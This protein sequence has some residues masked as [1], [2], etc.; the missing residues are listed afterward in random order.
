MGLE[1]YNLIGSFIK[2]PSD[3]PNSLQD[4]KLL[5]AKD[6]PASV[7]KSILDK[8]VSAK[9]LLFSAHDRWA[10]IE[11][12]Y[13]DKWVFWELDGSAEQSQ[14]KLLSSKLNSS[15]CCYHPNSLNEWL[16]IGIRDL[17]KCWKET[18]CNETSLDIDR[19]KPSAL[20]LDMKPPGMEMTVENTKEGDIHPDPVQYLSKKYYESLF[21]LRTPLAIFVKSKLVRLKIL[22]NGNGELSYR[23]VLET[24]LLSHQD[25]VNRHDISHSGLLNYILPKDANELLTKH[26]M[27]EF[28]ILL[29]STN[30][31]RI[32]QTADL[33]FILKAREVK[34]Q[35]ILLIELITISKMDVNFKAFEDDYKKIL[36]QRSLRVSKANFSIRRKRRAPIKQITASTQLSLLERL[37]FLLDKLSI[38]DIL[39]NSEPSIPESNKQKKELS[40]ANLIA[41]LKRHMLINENEASSIGFLTYVLIPYWSKKSP[42][43]V[44]FIANKI[45]GSY[46]RKDPSFKQPKLNRSEDQPVTSRHSSFSSTVTST[47]SQPVRTSLP[48]NMHNV[49]LPALLKSETQSS[50]TD[51][52]SSTTS[53]NKRP[54]MLLKSNTDLALN[55]LEKRQMSASDM[56]TLKILPKQNQINGTEH[57]TLSK[58]IPLSIHSSAVQSFKRVGKRKLDSSS[59]EDSKT[60]GIVQVTATPAKHLTLTKSIRPLEIVESPLIERPRDFVNAAI[61]VAAT[62]LKCARRE[63][64]LTMKNNITPITEPI[65]K[66]IKRRDDYNRKSAIHDVKTR[67]VRRKLFLPHN[68]GSA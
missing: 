42:H 25:L 14:A 35:I 16:S 48:P 31:E 26:I 11:R 32:S 13:G 5:D 46:V 34:L 30:P 41:E 12:Y 37:D 7:L 19:D 36:K 58:G 59:H 64:G 47:V 22:C 17:A 67:K 66:S 39:L 20:E 23:E 43:T 9:H 8:N 3:L 44:S 45:E 33:I 2:L 29:D 24:A 18:P 55:R 52:F 54:A 15:R 53:G 4:P 68:D 62:P 10:I 27:K 60:Q 51:F 28:N 38:I 21:Q 49:S 56:S 1:G 6:I 63:G 40:S 57:T 50:F 61:E 65:T